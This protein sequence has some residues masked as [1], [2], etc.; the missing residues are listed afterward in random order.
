ME[1]NIY[2]LLDDITDINLD[3]LPSTTTSEK[4]IKD[5]TIKKI[6]VSG[7]YL[8]PKHRRGYL[9]KV[10]L[11]AAITATLAI[12]V[13]AISVFFF[14]DWNAELMQYKPPE[15]DSH[16]AVGSQGKNWTVT[17][18][19]EDGEHEDSLPSNWTV[20]FT[21]DYVTSKGITCIIQEV[22]NEQ[23]HGSFAA[24]SRCWLE[25]WDGDAYVPLEGLFEVGNLSIQPGAE[26][27]FEVLWEN[28][29]GCLE[30][31]SY[32][33][34]RTFLYT[35]EN[36]DPRE[37]IFYAKFRI[38]SDEVHPYLFQYREAYQALCA[39]E[40][41][42][43]RLT[44][45]VRNSEFSHITEE[46]WKCG[47][48]YLVVYTFY[49]FDGSIYTSSG[50]MYRSSMG[51]GLRWTGETT[52]S[53]VA[54]WTNLTFVDDQYNT[55]WMHMAD[56][57]E[58]LI[59]QVFAENNT[60][61]FYEFYDDTD[62]S[63]LTEEQIAIRTKLD[64]YWNYNYTATEYSFDTNGSIRSMVKAQLLS[65]TQSIEEGHV[66]TQ[67]EVFDTS[68][69]AIRCTIQSVDVSRCGSFSWSEDRDAYSRNAIL[70]GFRNHSPEPISTPQEAIQAARREA[71]PTENPKYSEYYEY[72]L[73]SVFYDSESEMWKVHF[74]F[75]QDSEF[76][77][78]V[79][80]D[81]QGKTQMLVYHE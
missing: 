20:S 19:T 77:L 34:G 8:N 15:Y 43:I 66:I 80:L 79:Y 26:Y 7:K 76:S 5:L 71:V 37:L 41:L 75:S 48:D 38:L 24:G 47:E 42:H 54:E 52:A 18:G 61:C 16:P 74:R 6:N 31:G 32:R 22:G 29:I 55:S 28:S 57:N 1:I 40:S 17:Y 73:A 33:I 13:L 51:Y 67:L 50:H 60:I 14:A 49:N 25:K 35:P 59:G 72:N 39:Q 56:I 27:R 53:G 21:T 63:Q 4:R 30:P 58:A 2:D 70:A 9:A 69:E 64:P 44:R 45:Y 62:E 12:P 81:S 46:T 36:S 11:A 3:I 68:A 78:T 23:K 65:P 10:L